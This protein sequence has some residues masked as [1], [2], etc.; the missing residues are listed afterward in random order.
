MTDKQNIFLKRILPLLLAF[1][2]AFAF[3]MFYNRYLL[4]K[5]LANLKISL[6]K[7]EKMQDP[8]IV[9]T[10]KD[11][12]DDTFIM[13]VAREELDTSTLARIEFSS[14][15]ISSADKG[16]S[17]QDINE[18]LSFLQGLINDKQKDNTMNNN[19][20][21]TLTNIFPHLNFLLDVT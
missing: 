12:L 21:S 3:F 7:L 8:E 4:D 16:G 13:E 14:Q 6:Q 20:Y 15:L 2:G 11:I 9:R 10:V 19:H 5:T 18:A 17:Q 1:I